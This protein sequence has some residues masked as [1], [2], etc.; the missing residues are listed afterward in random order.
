MPTTTHDFPAAAIAETPLSRIATALAAQRGRGVLWLPVAMGMGVAFYFAL[1]SEPPGWWGLAVL[2]PALLAVLLLRG[3][4]AMLL[5]AAIAAAAAG[6]ALCELRV[7]LLPPVEPLPTMA[8]IV[9]GQVA[10][11]DLLPGGRRVV[12]RTP[13]INFGTTLERWVRVRLRAD[14]PTPVATGDR[15]SVRARFLAPSWPAYPGAAD[16]QRKAFFDGTAGSGFALGAVTMVAPGVPGG[17]GIAIRALRDRIVARIVTA[18]PGAEGGVAAAL[19]TGVV[20]AIPEPDLV[21]FRDSGL[22]HLLSVSGLHMAIV[23][24]LVMTVLRLAL[25]MLETPALRLPSKQIAAG[26]ALAAGAFYLLLTGSQVPTLRSYLMA[27]VVMVGIISGRPSLTLRTL[28][29]AAIVVLV[30]TPEQMIG[31]SFQMSFGAVLALIAGWEAVRGKLLRLRA[32]T[33]WAGM[34]LVY[35]AG[36]VLTSVL[37][38]LA[39]A[40]FAAYHFERAQLWSVASNMVAIPLTSVLVM[41]AGV[42][43][44]VLMPFGMEILALV[45]MGWGITATLHIAHAVASWPYAAVDVPVMPNWGL[46]CISLGMLWL[47]L[48]RGMGRHLGIPLI[49]AGALSPWQNPPPVVVVSQDARLIM[50]ASDEGPQLRRQPGAS[51][52]TQDQIARL[53]RTDSPAAFACQEAACHPPG[54]A[55]V[56]VERPRRDMPCA[57]ALLVVSAEPLRGACPGIL[58]IDRFDVWRN[59]A[60]AAWIDDG[61]VRIVSDRAW[62]GDRPWVPPEPRPRSRVTRD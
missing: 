37:A 4:Q 31:P 13:S 33:G 53:F 6:L 17:F 47:A 15:I 52:F 35:L 59:G 8:V 26:V 40:P 9:E 18:L 1:R 19:L 49:L 36:M 23:V 43:A 10:G 30:T 51:R 45:P 11:V 22:A 48:W 38:G 62:R 46:A 44:L 29:L 34:V 24:A 57:H 27:A 3:R 56:V 60:H 41:P 50:L 5:P 32:Q 42:L 25:V 20:T 55:V 39:T 54:S 14:D 28:A 7:A 21:A 58:A 61:V 2:L 12:M 16:F